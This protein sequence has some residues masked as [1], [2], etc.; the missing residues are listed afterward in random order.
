M[1]AIKER[2]IGAVTVMTDKDAEKIWNIIQ[3]TFAL[4]NAETVE[5]TEDELSALKAYQEGDSEFTATL[6]SD[7]IMREL[8]L[9]KNWIIKGSVTMNCFLCRGNVEKSTITYM[10][11]YNNRYIII[12]NVHNAVKSLSME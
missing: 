3:A 2:I 7:D 10:T 5:P 8:G 6:S 11:E 12:K 1:T 9:W 4:E